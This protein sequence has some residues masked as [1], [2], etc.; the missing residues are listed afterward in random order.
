[1]RAI[2][3][4][5]VQLK[6]LVRWPIVR[7][8]LRMLYAVLRLLVPTDRRQIGFVSTPDIAD[9]A[10]ALFEKIM[11]SPR[12]HEY[13]LVWLVADSLAS[14]H[15]LHREFK[16]TDPGNVSIMRK[17][18]LIGLWSF[19]R[20]RYVFFT[21]GAYGF[22]HSGYHQT[23][24]NLW[25]G[26]PFKNFLS[27]G[28][29][30]SDVPFMHYTIATSE[31]LADIVAENF[32]LPRER[33]L[34]TGLP[35]N[36]WLFVQERQYFAIKEGR[37]KLVVWLPTFRRSYF[38]EIRV[39]SIGDAPGALSL[40]ILAR[41]DEML[42]GAG[43]ILVIKPHPMDIQ[44]QKKWPSYRNIRIYA[45]PE[46]REKGL[47]LYKLLACSDALV[48]DFSSCAID[49]LLLNKPIG[50]FVPDIATYARGSIPEVLEKV[51][52]ITHKLDSVEDLGAFVKNPPSERDTAPER[53]ILCMTDHRDSSETILRSVG[54]GNLIP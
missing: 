19:V 5:Y 29:L 23:I 35:R 18:S 14:E 41:L 16:E 54:L 7:T 37:A 30:Q 3:L 44:N 38:G 43:V 25:H 42:E 6:Q 52:A 40:E 15:A 28:E 36:E 47:N 9:N 11:Q 4:T 21:H 26:M 50:I 1:M 22:A 46:F 12:A 24:V 17:N 51:A 34:V 48:T 32:H 8:C 27:V 20:C 13:R 53:E 49:Y 2:N 31:Y 45:D 33:V 39:D 10:L